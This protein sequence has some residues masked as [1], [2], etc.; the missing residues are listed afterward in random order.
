MPADSMRWLDDLEPGAPDV[1]AAY[2]GI[3]EGRFLTVRREVRRRAGP[4]TAEPVVIELGAIAEALTAL[5]RV[6][7]D[8]AFSAPGGEGDWNVAEAI[9][10]TADSRAGLSMAG[11]LAATG[12]FPADAPAVV[13]GIP[14]ER[15]LGRE[16]LARRIAVSQRVVERAARSIAGHEADPCPLVHP[17]VGRLRCGE[18]LFFAGVHDLMHLEQLHGIAATFSPSLGE[19]PGTGA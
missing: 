1:V 4:G 13:Q 19:G 8:G 12:R 5:V 2:R 11:A 7:P 6:L 15:G 14:G 18:W 10:H 16:A 3:E 17:Q 9:G